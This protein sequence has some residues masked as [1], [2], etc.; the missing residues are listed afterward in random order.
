MTHYSNHYLV[1]VSRFSGKYFIFD[2]PSRLNNPFPLEIHI[3]SS[4]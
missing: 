3:Y 2:R 1:P 4:N